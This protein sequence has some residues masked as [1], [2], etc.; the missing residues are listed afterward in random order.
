MFKRVFV[1]DWAQIIPTV[2]F[3]IFA[4]VFLL[5]TIRAM[6][7]RQPERERLAGLPLEDQKAASCSGCSNC[8]NCKKTTLESSNP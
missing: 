1:E 8:S 6:R 4:V 3:C 2:S 5:V 7:L